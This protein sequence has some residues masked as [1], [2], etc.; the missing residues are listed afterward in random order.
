VYWRSRGLGFHGGV[1][2]GHVP[3]CVVADLWVT[4]HRG[5]AFPNVGFDGE[6]T[7]G[8]RITTVLALPPL[9]ARDRRHRVVSVLPHH[10]DMA[11]NAVLVTNSNVEIVDDQA[12]R[13]LPH[14]V[15]AVM[16]FECLVML[17]TML[18][19]DM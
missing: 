9:A 4:H 17:A 7:G 14:L 11:W 10:L 1:N 19:R 18:M 6:F 13:R 2:F 8:R 5:P 3:R 15:L 16:K 12:Q